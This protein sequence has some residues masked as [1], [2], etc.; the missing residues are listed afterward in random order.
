MKK[1]IVCMSFLFLGALG[2]DA[3]TKGKTGAKKGQ[4]TRNASGAKKAQAKKN[5]SNNSNT[6]GTTTVLN[7]IGTYN[8]YG[9]NAAPAGRLQISDPTIRALN[10]RAFSRTMPEVEGSGIIGMHKLAYGVANGH[11]LFRSTDAPTSGTSTGSGSVG[12]GTN[13][14][15][16]GTA[17]HAIGVNGKNPYAGPGIYGLPLN[18][19][20]INRASSEGSRPRAI[21]QKE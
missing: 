17:G 3:Q 1:V 12:T 20:N 6:S 9:R 16:V 21:R 7:S 11:I 15:P 19:G 14:G 4:V 18:D 13:V 5:L 8:A 10:E 2:A